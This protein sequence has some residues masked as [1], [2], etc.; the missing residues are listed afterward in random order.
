VA[1]LAALSLEAE[2]RARRDLPRVS[3]RGLGDQVVVLG[4][5]LAGALE[6]ESSADL[7]ERGSQVLTS[8]RR[9]V[10]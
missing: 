8:I 4:R 5:D 10:P 7:L 9:A 3:A 6:R 2:G 1:E